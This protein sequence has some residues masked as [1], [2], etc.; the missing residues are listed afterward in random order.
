MV[1]TLV[2]ALKGDLSTCNLRR[3]FRINAAKT[4]AVRFTK[5]GSILDYEKW[6]NNPL[7]QGSQIP[8]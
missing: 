3:R 7:V 2:G 4:V 6:G 8:D 5:K 1:V